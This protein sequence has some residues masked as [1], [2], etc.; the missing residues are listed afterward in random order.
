MAG[1]PGSL[2]FV[3]AKVVRK[4]FADDQEWAKFSKGSSKSFARSE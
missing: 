3:L 1:Q 2:I 4:N